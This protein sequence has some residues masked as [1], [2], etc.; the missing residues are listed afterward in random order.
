M[1]RKGR[2]GREDEH[3][4]CLVGWGMHATGEQSRAQD[5][6]ALTLDMNILMAFACFYRPLATVERKTRLWE[7]LSFLRCSP[8]EYF[9]SLE[10]TVF[11]TVY[12]FVLSL[13]H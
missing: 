7:N 2:K 1:E 12:T 8:G 10:L 11:A 9:Q 5:Q 13:F 6:P 3:L 4:G